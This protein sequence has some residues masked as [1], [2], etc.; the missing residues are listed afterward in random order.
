VEKEVEALFQ[1]RVEL[2]NGGSIVID[3]TEALVAIDV[4]SG[5][6]KPGSDLEE[7]AF[8]TNMEAIPEIVRQLRLRDLGGVIII[9]FID[10]G[11]DKHRRSVE[12]RLIDELRGDRSRI[13]VGRISAFGLLE[14]TRQRVGPGLKRTVF[15]SCPHCKG[16]GLTRTVT[17]KALSVLREVRAILSLK[18]FSILQVYASPAVADFLANLKRR[19][20]MDLEEVIGK[21]VLFKAEGSYP[22]DVVHYRF[23]TGDGQEARVNI[24]AGLGVKA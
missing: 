4:N 20:V 19:Q 14:I 1:P 18:G 16:T 7:T 22:I 15:T 17:S 23:M 21:T 24:P 5:R 10:M 6:F 2:Q 11:E 13:K 12:R 8:K 9:D 3:Q